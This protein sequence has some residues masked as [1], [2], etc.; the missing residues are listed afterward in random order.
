MAIRV[1]TVIMACLLL[2]LSPHQGMSQQPRQQ[3]PSRLGSQAPINDVGSQ[4]SRLRTVRRKFNEW[5]SV[6]KVYSPQQA[7]ELRQILD[8]K[9]RSMS[10]AQL[11]DFLDEMEEKLQVLLGP[12]AA[13][14]RTYM[15]EFLNQ[16]GQQELLQQGGGTPDVL[17]M[18]AAQIQQELQKFKMQRQSTRA[19][20][21][22]FD[23]T[24]ELGIQQYLQGE[25]AR[26]A[27]SERAKDRA[28]SSASQTQSNYVSP[29][30]PRRE[31]QTT[32]P[33]ATSFSV[34]PFGGLSIS[35]SLQ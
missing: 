17:S 3:P 35:Y 27:S 20:Y 6:Q 25:R 28:V 4:N 14:A 29:Y 12:D 2:A 26:A 8:S 5:L 11:E 32:R 22:A 33:G 13:Q 18:S 23:R 24:R 31:R 7:A 34:G 1:L 19:A 10:S 21:S 15:D 9:T 16:R 30:A